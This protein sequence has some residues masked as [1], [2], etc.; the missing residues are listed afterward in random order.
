MLKRSIIMLNGI[1]RAFL[2][3]LVQY[4]GIIYLQETLNNHA[5]TLNN[6]AKWNKQSI[7]FSFSAI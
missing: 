6:H 5:K 4:E 2:S 3:H 1:N 7:S